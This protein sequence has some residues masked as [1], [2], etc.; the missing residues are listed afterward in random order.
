L[1]SVIVAAYNE[2]KHLRACIESLLS[3]QGVLLE[4]IVVNDASTDLTARI[5][6]KIEDERVVT[7]TNT[8]RL[9]RAAARNRAVLAARGDVIAIQDADDVALPGRLIALNDGLQ[10]SPDVAAIGGQC[11][12]LDARWGYWRHADYPVDQD[13]VKQS[14]DRGVMSVCHAGSAIRKSVF[15]D[16]GGYDP[17]FVR[18]Q[19][20]DL[21]YRIS[22]SHA[23]CGLPLDVVV[24]RTPVFISWTYWRMTRLADTRVRGS[25]MPSLARAM[26]WYSLAMTRRLIRY[27]RT[28]RAESLRMAGLCTRGGEI[29]NHLWDWTRNDRFS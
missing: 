17:T 23:V 11:V 24:Y 14:F 19:D 2:E 26:L 13:E 6:A 29:E 20:L 7:I 25:S 16:L 21:F 15:L 27:A 12:A 1:I 28:H 22:R 10:S 9:G 18:G 5:L 4:V 8:T 3:Q